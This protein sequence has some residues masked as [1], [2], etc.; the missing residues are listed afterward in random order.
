MYKIRETEKSINL[1]YS[2]IDGHHHIFSSQGCRI[3]STFSK[4]VGFDQQEQHKHKKRQL[5]NLSAPML[6]SMS[7]HLFFC[8]QWMELKTDVESLAQCLFQYTDYLECSKKRVMTNH[9]SK[10]PVHEVAKNINFQF[11][12]ASR[13]KRSSHL[14][15]QSCLE[16]V[17]DFQHVAVEDVISTLD[18][19]AKYTLIKR[20][21]SNGFP[22]PTALLS[23]TNGNNVGNLH[24]IWIVASADVT[25]FSESQKV[26]GTIRRSIPIFHT[27]AMRQEMFN[28]FDRVASS[29]KPR[30]T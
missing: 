28:V 3:P 21:K 12:P 27:R 10:S 23:Y 18:S 8:L 30:S 13:T 2:V 19:R 24:F 6:Q 7:E 15:L 1:L 16:Q 17:S 26:I 14:E 4:F 5:D 9:Y 22:F 20:M 29:V 25:S 11:L